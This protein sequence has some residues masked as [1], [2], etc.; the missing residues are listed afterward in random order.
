MNPRRLK[1]E[2]GLKIDRDVLTLS[3]TLMIEASE[4]SNLLPFNLSNGCISFE[5]DGSVATI[6]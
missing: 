5:L 4:R 6:Q 1:W 3:D 2:N